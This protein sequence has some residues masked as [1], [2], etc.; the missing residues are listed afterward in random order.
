MPSTHTSLHYH[1][2]FSTRSRARL[3][4]D[5]WRAELH[6]FLGGT[7]KSLEGIPLNVGGVEDH[8]HLLVGLKPIHKLA[9]VLRDL[10]KSSTKW[11]H[12]RGHARQFTWQKGYGAFTV[13]KSNL[14]KVRQYI[15]DQE[16]HH[17]RKTF[18][19]E[20]RELL[21]RHGIEY[22]ERYLW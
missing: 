22:D 19:E 3:I 15:G 7:I 9:D 21:E 13:S 10:K 6:R 2:V 20:Y 17:K 16:E 5:E 8:V 4:H 1:I 11:I 12:E 18:Q 14:V